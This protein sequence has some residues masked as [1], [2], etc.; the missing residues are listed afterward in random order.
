M[1]DLNDKDD[2][3][4]P[5][6][7]LA[8]WL[9]FGGILVFVS[10]TVISAQLFAHGASWAFAGLAALVALAGL[11]AMMVGLRREAMA[12]RSRLS[13]PERA[14]LRFD[15]LHVIWV[16]GFTFSFLLA[17]VYAPQVEHAVLRGGIIAAPLIM[18]AV[19]VAEFVR[20]IVK[21]D[22]H[23]RAQH[24]AACAIAGGAVVVGAT[25]WSVLN[26]LV[27]IWPEPDAWTLL[28]TYAVIYGV[29]H[30]ILARGDQ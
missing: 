10:A 12:G 15:Q 13:T 18:L 1:D 16:L 7:L 4:P 5:A 11:I 9:R 6:A 17:I 14:R 22:E 19:L 23:Q 28:P 24:L 26:E 30:A 3:N 29:T 27:G 8:S 20:M 21:S 2:H 25:A